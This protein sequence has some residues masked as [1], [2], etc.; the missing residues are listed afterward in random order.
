[1]L[2]DGVLRSEGSNW[3]ITACDT[4]E[5]WKDRVSRLSWESQSW[6]YCTREYR[7]GSPVLFEE[8][9][10]LRENGKL[11]VSIVI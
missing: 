6:V 9:I 2:Q 5:N 8:G 3:E 10:L 1:M 7:T 11:A 4:V